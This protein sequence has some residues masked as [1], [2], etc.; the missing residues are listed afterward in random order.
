MKSVLFYLLIYFDKKGHF[1]G[2]SYLQQLWFN[3]PCFTGL[4]IISSSKWSALPTTYFDRNLLSEAELVAVE[5]TDYGTHSLLHTVNRDTFL[6]GS[7]AMFHLCMYRCVIISNPSCV[8][9]IYLY[10]SSYGIRVITWWLEHHIMTNINL[11]FHKLIQ[12]EWKKQPRLRLNIKTVFP[13]IGISMLKTRR[14]RDRL[15]FNRAIPILV[16]RHLC[17]KTSPGIV[18]KHWLSQYLNWP[19]P[20]N[21]KR[22]GTEL[23]GLT[24]SISWL[25]MP[26]LLTSPGHQQ[27]WYWLCRI[28]RSWSYLRKD[29]KNI[30]HFNVE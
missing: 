28:C 29:F 30:C 21:P 6:R 9:E 2:C 10:L 13:G 3:I 26:W 18:I 15:I 11:S 12:P 8:K 23:T 17:I 20:F 25:L 1:E 24:R 22:A 7:S 4:D 19:L 27:P 5:D 14:S 16:R